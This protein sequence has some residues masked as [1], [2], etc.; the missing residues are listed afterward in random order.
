MPAANR[1][2]RVRAT[3]PAARTPLEVGS[4]L[5][6]EEYEASGNLG[7]LDILRRESVVFFQPRASRFASRAPS[8]P[9]RCA[10]RQNRLSLNPFGVDNTLRLD[11]SVHNKGKRA[12]R[13]LSSNSSYRERPY[14]GVFREKPTNRRSGVGKLPQ[15]HRKQV[16]VEGAGK[17][18]NGKSHRLLQQFPG[19]RSVGGSIAWRR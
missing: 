18:G 6:K 17:T 1:I 10:W 15:V 13:Q 19:R 3:V 16:H 9:A 2:R 8:G 14:F 4:L 5:G 11:R 12:V 7:D